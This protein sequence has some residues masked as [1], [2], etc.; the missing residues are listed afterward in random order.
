V[1]AVEVSNLLSGLIGSAIG[2]VGGFA[3][4]FFIELWR[5]RRTRVGI[6][7]AM[8]GELQGNAGCATQRILHGVRGPNRI[9][10]RF[11]SQTWQVAKF[12]LAQFVPGNLY[13]E[14]LFIYDTLPM[15]EGLSE[16]S[17]SLDDV[18]D[19][20][21]DWIEGVKK[22]MIRLLQLPEAAAFRSQWNIR[23]AEEKPIKSETRSGEVR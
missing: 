6:V 23:L 17:G 2:V 19:S 5:V 4:A 22:A 12:D 14:L 11:S 16:A 18:K 3:G 1:I 13:R 21:R 15:V 20:A 9:G 10:M 8:L 7:H